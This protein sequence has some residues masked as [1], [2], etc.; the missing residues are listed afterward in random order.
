MRTHIYG[1]LDYRSYIKDLIASQ[2][3]NGRGE[4][5]KISEA[6]NCQMSFITHV[7]NGEKDFSPEQIF[8]IAELYHLNENEKEFLIE[9]LSYNRAG[10]LELK[11]YFGKKLILKKEQFKLLKNRLQETQSLTLEAQAEYYSHW[12]YGAIHIA[13]TIPSLQSIG[14]LAKYFNI[15]EVELRHILNFLSK[16]NL[17]VL[18]NGKIKIGKAHLFVGKDS[19]LSNQHH[20]IWRIKALNDLK[21]NKPEDF[22]YSLCFSVS[23]KDWPV[24]REKLLETIYD[25][26]KQLT[27]A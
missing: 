11:D 20:S 24:L 15:S 13:A 16:N 4:R 17:T 14:K 25:C 9:M 2:P 1:Y 3:L 6:L 18:E 8:K 7:F 27:I 10:T 19:P 26:L 23:E 12:L 5:K 21:Q 22:H